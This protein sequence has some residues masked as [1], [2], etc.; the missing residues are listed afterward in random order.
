MLASQTR[1][2]RPDRL[3]PPQLRDELSRAGEIALLD[4]R[5][6]G[7]FTH[8]HLLLAACAPLW[9]LELL[10]DRLVPRSTTRVV[11]TDEDGSLLDAAADKLHYLG[12][13]DM[14]V[15]DGGTSAWR[16]AGFEVFIDENVPGKALGEVVEAVAGTPHIDV[17]ELRRRQA[18]GEKLVVVD[19]RTP[20]EFYHFSLPGAHSLPNGELAYRIRELAPDPQTLVVVNCAGRTRSIIGAQTLIN[21]GIPNPVVALK[22]GTMDWL[23]AGHQLEHARRTELPEPTAQHINAARAGAARLARRAGVAT[24]DAAGLADFVADAERTLYRFDIRTREEYEAG[25]LPGFRWAP[26][27]QLVQATDG[28]LATRGARIVI[29]DWDGVRAQGTAAWLLQLGGYDIYLY[30]PAAD[31]IVEAGSEPVRV[32]R[33]PR[34]PEVALLTPQRADSLLA[35]GSAVLI[36]VDNSLSFAR[37]HS[38]G[39]KFIAPQRLLEWL[40]RFAPRRVILTSRDGVLARQIAGELR[41]RNLPAAALLGGAN[42]WVAAGL[43]TEQGGQDVLTGEDDARYGG[44]N[45]SDPERR[46]RLFRDYLAWEI[47]LVEQLGRPGAELQ[48]QVISATAP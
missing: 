29:A 45:V 4:V 35:D 25:H 20:E 46:E 1:P 38:A 22:N 36:D 19:G 5:E 44:Y 48:F 12:Y 39:A 13:S 8:G 43:P 27:G 26:G 40:P 47:G 24:I 7:L 18:A 30:A 10:I 42:A 31:S 33:D 11:L 15:L 34:A 14:A 16:A 3:T 6:Y 21:A 2:I 37:Q 28:F 41:R 32:R 23:L 17:G 9:R